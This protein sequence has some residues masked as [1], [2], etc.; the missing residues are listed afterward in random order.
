MTVVSGNDSDLAACR[1]CCSSASCAS[2][3]DRS[4]A[5]DVALELHA[6]VG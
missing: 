5:Q 3:A 2:R 1:R 6:E 4:D